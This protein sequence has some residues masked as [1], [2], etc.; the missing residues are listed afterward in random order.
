MRLW[1]RQCP[2]LPPNWLRQVNYGTGKDVSLETM[3][4]GKVPLQV[5]WS[6]RSYIKIPLSKL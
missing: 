3:E 4:D 2:N 1:P 5:K 6:N